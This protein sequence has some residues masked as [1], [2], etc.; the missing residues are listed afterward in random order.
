MNKE[1]IIQ[2]QSQ[3]DTLARSH[4][5]A[6]N[7]DWKETRCW[8]FLVSVWV[9]LS[10]FSRVCYRNPGRCPGLVWH[11]PLAF[12]STAPTARLHTSLGQRP[13]KDAPKPHEG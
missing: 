9:G 10:A 12:N 5:E 8:G 6:T 1:L 4:P 3:F 11:R 13:R 2:M 7:V